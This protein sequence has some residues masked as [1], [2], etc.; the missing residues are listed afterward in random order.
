MQVFARNGRFLTQWSAEDIAPAGFD[1]M[2]IGV[3]DDD[4]VYIADTENNRVVVF[5]LNQ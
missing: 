2:G 4:R 1:P 5:S 3:D